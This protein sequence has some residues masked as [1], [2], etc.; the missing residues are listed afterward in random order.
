MAEFDLLIGG[1]SGADGFS[2]NFGDIP[3]TGSNS[4]EESQ[5]DELSVTFDTWPNGPDD[6]N[7]IEVWYGG[8]RLFQSAENRP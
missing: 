3:R 1:G 7:R 8:T 2:F 4:W 5:I 6:A